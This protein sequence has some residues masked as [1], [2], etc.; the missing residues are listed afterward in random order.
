MFAKELAIVDLETSGTSPEGARI[1]EFAMVRIRAGEL[2]EEWST[3]VNPGTPIPPMIQSMTGI[4]DRMVA[5]APRFAEVAETIAGKLEGCVLVAHNARFDYGFLKAEFARTGVPF[6]AQTLCTVRLSRALYPHEHSHGLDALIARH[7][8]PADQRHRALGDARIVWAFLQLIRASFPG[9][10]IEAA[11]A[12]LLKRPSLPPHLP[13]ETLERIPAAPGVYV[14]YGASRHPLYIGK[15]VNLRERVG[16]HF[17]I[18]QRS[19]RDLRL[20]REI[21]DIEWTETAGELGALLREAELVKA[22]LP[23]HNVRLRRQ[24]QATVLRL[25]EGTGKARFLRAAD[26]D[27]DTL[28]ESYGVF[29]SR[30]QARTALE[31]IAAEHRLCFKLLG[32]E[33]GTGPCFASQLQRCN[34]AC[35]GAETLQDH[36]RRAVDAM[37]SMRTAPWPFQGAVA[38]REHGE[39]IVDL[40]VIDRWCFLGTVATLAEAFALAQSGRRRFEADAYRILSGWLKKAD[41]AQIVPL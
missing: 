26:L 2:A 40:H 11:V 3:L 16:S 20:S 1:T 37:A 18:D 31:A 21:A 32:L 28:L 4:T 38:I 7:R 17:S 6:S 14:F 35:I 25:H 22:L 39:L 15:S 30:R 33:P 24:E 5:R 12:R 10:Q 41:T 23:A 34:G 13:A 27:L 29:Q 9:A 19:G 36:T 8:L